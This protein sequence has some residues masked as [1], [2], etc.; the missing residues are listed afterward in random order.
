MKKSLFIACLFMT[1]AFMNAQVKT[2]QPSPSTKVIQT[3]GMTEVTLEYSRPGMKD[4]VIF[5]DLVPYDTMWRTGANKNT[6]ITFADDVKIEGKDVLA[7]TYAIF[8]KPGKSSWDVYFYKDT[9]NWG[10]P[11]KWSEDKVAAKVTIASMKTRDKVES[12]TIA[13]D[14]LRNNF[15]HLTFAWENTKAAVKLEVPTK[16]KALAS[17]EKVMA[18]PS[19]R[20]YFNA[21]GFYMDENMDMTKAKEMMDMA[22]EKRGEKKAYWYYRR[23][24]LINAELGDKKAAVKAAKTSLELAE[25]AGNTSYVAMNKKSLAEWK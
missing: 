8:I 6:M 17:I 9:E 23:L 11:E 22:I 19:D 15:A 3:V 13:F 4:R 1:I 10:T 7:G 5:G 12:F 2:P 25:K 16:A 24:A 14:H 21:A 20:D 18:G